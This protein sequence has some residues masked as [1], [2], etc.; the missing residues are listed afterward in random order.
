METHVGATAAI[1]RGV[2]VMTT[3][4]SL[5]PQCVVLAEEAVSPMQTQ[6][7]RHLQLDCPLHLARRHLVVSVRVSGH[8]PVKSHAQEAAAIPTMTLEAS[9]AL[10]W[11]RVARVQTGDIALMLMLALAPMPALAHL[12]HKNAL[13]LML[14]LQTR[15]VMCVGNTASSRS[16]AL[17]MMM[18]TSRHL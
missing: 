11:M 1:Q 5:R 10:W 4:T 16:G 17:G 7:S 14:A 18:M 8:C 13:T 15:M 3:K 6:S 2:V 9:G 12:V